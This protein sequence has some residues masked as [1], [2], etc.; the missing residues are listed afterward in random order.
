MNVRSF[1][2]IYGI[3]FTLSGV[4]PFIPG[5]V[6]PHEA[7]EHELAIR[8]GA[9]DFL[10]VFP[11]NT[12]HNMVHLAFGIWGVVAHRSTRAAR[13]YACSVVVVFAVLVV[14]GL[15]PRLNTLFGFVPLHG[16]DVWLHA[17][18]AAGAAYFGFLQ[19][20]SQG[21]SGGPAARAA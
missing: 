2:L 21:Q 17:L 6:T 13:G 14:A 1:A 19:P 4:L 11:T 16:S 10:G 20:S 18:L 8:H 7:L 15:I 9:G 5:I 3:V 12:V